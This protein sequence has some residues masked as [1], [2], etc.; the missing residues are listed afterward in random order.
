MDDLKQVLL[1]DHAIFLKA[2]TKADKVEFDAFLYDLRTKR[3]LTRVTKAVAAAQVE[4]Q[5]GSLASSLYLNV[6]YSPELV[7]PKD[8]PPPPK[9]V[10]PPLYKTW[11][12]WTGTVAILGIIAGATAAI[13]LTRPPTCPPGAAC[14]Q[15]TE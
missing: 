11:W 6:N 7:A 4:S 8:K 9:L 5:L 12:F 1:I 14:F 3:K 2:A 15:V 10:R 13:V